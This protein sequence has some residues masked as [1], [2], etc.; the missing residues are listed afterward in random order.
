MSL[1]NLPAFFDMVYVNKDN[2]RLSTDGY[3]YND[4][5]FQVLNHLVELMNDITT[6]VITSTSVTLNGLNPPSLTT[7]Q[8]DALVAAIPLTLPLGTIWYD[9]DVNKLKVLVSLA[10]V[11]TVQTI[12][13]T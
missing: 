12:T 9:S 1:I 13:S 7:A 3:L 5:T 11:P 2:G 4:Q 8:I 6:T 10:G